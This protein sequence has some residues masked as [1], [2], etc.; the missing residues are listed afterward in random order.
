MKRNIFI[1]CCCILGIISLLFFSNCISM[2][3][4]GKNE[5]LNLS[6]RPKENW[7][8]KFNLMS[9][10]SLSNGEEKDNCFLNEA[11][12]KFNE[13]LCGNINNLEKKWLCYRAVAYRLNDLTICD[14]IENEKEKGNCYEE[15]AKNLSTCELIKDTSI[16]EICISRLAEKLQDCEKIKNETSIWKDDCYSKIA[17]LNK[18]LKICNKIKDSVI[19]NMCKENVNAVLH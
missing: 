2:R 5:N 18:N 8:Q 11:Y 10:Y 1:Y 6:T 16:R 17:L 15:L 3:E 14:K 9:C 4:E 7:H 13:N 12:L 19:K